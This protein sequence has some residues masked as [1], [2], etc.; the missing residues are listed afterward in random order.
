MSDHE[1]A[2]PELKLED[3]PLDADEEKPEVV[4]AAAPAEAGLGDDDD[5]DDDGPGG[6]PPSRAARR[7]PGRR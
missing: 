6:R 1:D 4:P 5:D 3:A 2:A 7:G